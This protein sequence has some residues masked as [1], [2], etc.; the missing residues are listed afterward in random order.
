[1]VVTKR[2]EKQEFSLSMI[3]KVIKLDPS[4]IMNDCEQGMDF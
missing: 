4:R 3:F 2:D 1:M